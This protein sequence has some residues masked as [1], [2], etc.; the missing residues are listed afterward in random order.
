MREGGC[1]SRP[2]WTRE[3]VEVRSWVVEESWGVVVRGADRSDSRV[4]RR[5]SV[6][7]DTIVRSG[8]GIHDGSELI[9]THHCTQSYPAA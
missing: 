4:E 1:I 6:T 2:P 8:T 5:R 3:R 9:G 7:V